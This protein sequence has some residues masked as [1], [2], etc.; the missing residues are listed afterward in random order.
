MGNILTKYLSKNF[1]KDI[2]DEIIQNIIETD[3]L[4]L[5]SPSYWGDVT[6]QM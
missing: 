3:I 1:C 6:A 2:M 5:A 4:V